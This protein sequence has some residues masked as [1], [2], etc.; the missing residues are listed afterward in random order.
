MSF[1]EEL[2]VNGEVATARVGVPME[3]AWIGR[4]IGLERRR[5]D[6]LR[7]AIIRAQRAVVDLLQVPD[8]VMDDLKISWITEDI[9]GTGWN[10][11]PLN[12]LGP[13]TAV[14]YC[15]GVCVYA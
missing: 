9:D 10:W 4:S 8:M 6:G 5:D 1:S 12:A 15:I 14:L 2:T 7:Q 11:N 13:D 3:N